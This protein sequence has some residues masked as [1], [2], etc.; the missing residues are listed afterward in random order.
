MSALDPRISDQ[1]GAAAPCQVIERD[2]DRGLVGIAQRMGDIV[3]RRTGPLHDRGEASVVV[4]LMIG[5]LGAE[6]NRPQPVITG[7][8]IKRD[9][10]H[11][12]AIG[13]AADQRF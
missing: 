3:R 13:I 8:A 5:V 12:F 2:L 11:W 7:A 1:C 9:L 4:T 10:A 6:G